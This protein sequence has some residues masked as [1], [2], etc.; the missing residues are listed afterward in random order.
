MAILAVFFLLQLDKYT[1][2]NG[3][4]FKKNN[5]TIHFLQQ[6][7]CNKVFS[8]PKPPRAHDWKLLVKNIRVTLRQQEDAAGKIIVPNCCCFIIIVSR[9]SNKTLLATLWLQMFVSLVYHN[10]IAVF[11]SA[12]AYHWSYLTL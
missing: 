11:S 8:P 9:T 10:T 2:L 7:P 3:Q 1:K 12:K 6:E 4:Q 5:Y